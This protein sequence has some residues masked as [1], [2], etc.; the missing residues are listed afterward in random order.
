MTPAA[1]DPHNDFNP[2]L[3]GVLAGVKVAEFSQNAA[4]PQCGR[5]LA[6]MGADVIKIEPLT[7]D[8]MRHVAKLSDT[9]SRAF[10]AINPGKRSLALDM[11]ADGAPQIINALLGWADIALV[12]LK[13]PDLKRFGL[14]WETVQRINPGLVELQVTA[15]GPEGPDANMP[16]YDVLVQARSG[17]GFMMNRS[18]D[19]VPLPTRPAFID[20]STGAMAT[21][22]VLGALR[23]RDLTGNG[24]RIDASLLGTGMSL[25][26][27]NTMRFQRDVPKFTELREDLSMLQQAGADFDDQ[28]TLYEERVTGSAGIYL[29][30]F[31]HYRTA[32]GIVSLAGM[33]PGLIARFHDL[34]AV[35]VPP[36][37]NSNDPELLAVV[38]QAE[39]L[40]MAHTTDHWMQ[41]LEDGGYPCARYQQPFAA[42]DD[43]QNLI[44]GYV[45]DVEHQVF[46]EYRTLGMPFTYSDTPTGLA[47]PSPLLGQH[48]EEIL[49]QLGFDRPSIAAF[50]AAEV[51][52]TQPE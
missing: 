46:G 40:F 11:T 24:Q 23:H 33:S 45:V 18:R 10:S 38:A 25:A 20:F 8:S 2:L 3:S 43:E 22:A 49:D 36:T 15:F 44:N 42:L 31:R 1:A 50:H 5:L 37:R 47:G 4:V 12:G 16:G 9:E 7:G 14:D 39:A 13:R 17:L 28:R 6:G 27:A 29:L 30:Y 34:T 48:S 51:I 41:L 21:A 52:R 32:D 26:T 35:P 19:G